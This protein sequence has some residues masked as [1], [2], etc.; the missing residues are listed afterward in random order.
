MAMCDSQLERKWLKALDDSR[1]RPPTHAQFL[2]EACSTRPDFYYEDHRAAIYIDGPPHDEPEAKQEDEA[3]TDA[4]MEA[5]YLVIRF[6][7]RDDWQS[8]F[9]KYSDVFGGGR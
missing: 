2:I 5:G 7:H 1:L 8:L 9:A 6:H 3:I 4:L